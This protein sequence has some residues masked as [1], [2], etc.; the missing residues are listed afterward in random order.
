[1]ENIEDLRDASSSN[2]IESE[3]TVETDSD[4]TELTCDRILE[5]IGGFGPYQILVG[6]ATGIALLLS[7]FSLMNFIFA[8]GIPEHR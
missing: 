2:S 3:E 1:M 7:S 4:K 5:E 6:I 8:S